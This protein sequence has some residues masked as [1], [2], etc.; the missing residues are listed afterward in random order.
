MN[1][2]AFLNLSLHSFNQEG[3]WK[4]FFDGG[5][6]DLFNLYIHSKSKKS[7]LF[8]DYFIDKK[9]P[10]GWGQF[11]LVEATIELIKVA[12]E[13]EDNEYF[14]L[15][16]DSHLPLYSL[17]ETVSLI[18]ERYPKTTF[19]KHFSFH[20]KVKSQ[21]TFKKG[22]KDYKFDK[23]NAVCQFFVLRRKDAIKFVETFNHWS[24]YF[25]K[26]EVIF[27]DEFYFWGVAREIGID[28]DMGQ[29]TTYSDWSVRKDQH[30]KISRNPRA[31]ESFSRAMMQNYRDRNFL[32]VRKIMPETFITVNL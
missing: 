13:D 22:I 27:A 30:G 5:D 14:S 25:V 16:S 8:S 32:Y 29:A 20:T 3:V 19:A 28:F 7:R 1:K 6:E 26:D 2:V 24:R 31:F 12:L 18:K 15:I 9:V 23:Y 17:D 11:S 10:T 4:K 21:L